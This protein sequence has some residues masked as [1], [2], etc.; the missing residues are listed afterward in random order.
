MS[1][2]NIE[3]I[4]LQDG[5]DGED[6]RP[7]GTRWYVSESKLKD[8]KPVDGSTWWVA[9]EQAPPPTAEKDRPDVAGPVPRRRSSE[10]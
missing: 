2:T 6:Y 5:H 4:A 3:V 10:P 1:K 9:V 8:G 7:A